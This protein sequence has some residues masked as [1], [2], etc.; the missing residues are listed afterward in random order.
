MFIE[1]GW[2]KAFSTDS[3]TTNLMSLCEHIHSQIDA[4]K[5]EMVF[6]IL[7]FAECPT[8]YFGVNC[9]GRCH[10]ENMVSCDKFN[11]TCP[12]VCAP[13]YG[14]PTCSDLLEAPIKIFKN[15]KKWR[16]SKVYSF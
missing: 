6:L 12:G 9:M 10:C 2:S 7:A 16:K 1:I 5:E 13:T 14:G 11:G 4:M 15:V 3:I 8:S